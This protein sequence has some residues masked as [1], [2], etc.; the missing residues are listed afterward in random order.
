MTTRG[1]AP[2]IST[3]M[4]T[5][6]NRAFSLATARGEVYPHRRVLFS[7]PQIKPHQ[8]PPRRDPR[9]ELHNPDAGRD[10]EAWPSRPAR[11]HHRHRPIHQLEQRLVRVT[12][13]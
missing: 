5:P 4:E 13:Q 1:T 3:G 12:L 2:P 9:L 6:T 10:A 8:P 7:T 11:V